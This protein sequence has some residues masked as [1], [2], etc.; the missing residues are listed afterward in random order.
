MPT[1]ISGLGSGLDID[2]LVKQTMQAK[3]VPFDQ[4]RQKMTYLG[5]QRDA[6]R[7]MNTDMSGLLKE[8]QKL[9]FESNVQ[10]KKASMTTSDAEKVIATPSAG[11]V[12][13]NF[14]L[15]VN[16][17]AKSASVTSGMVIGMSTNQL[18]ASGTLTITGSVGS[19]TVDFVV[20][21]NVSQ[22]VSKINSKTSTT[23]VK[24]I[25]DQLSDKLTLTNTQTGAAGN[26]LRIADSG[27]TNTLLGILKI[28]DTDTPDPTRT[29]DLT[30]TAQTNVS[31]GQDA[32]VNFNNTG[33]VTVSSNSFTMNNINFTLLKDPAALGG[34]YT[35]SGSTNT[36]VDAIV[37]TIKGVF[38]KYNDL[39]DKVN[40]K[41]SEPKYRDY[42]PLSDDQKAEMKEADI[43]LWEEKAKSGLLRRDSVLSNG[44]EKMRHF[45]SESVTG[46]AAGQYNSMADIGITT[47][48]SS[49]ASSYQAYLENGKIY[50]DE[51]KLRNALTNSPD[52]VAALFTKDGARDVNGKLTN[53]TDAGIGTRLNEI[54][55]SDIISGLTQKTQI[56][57]T[58]SY[59]NRQID[60]YATRIS[61]GESVLSKYEQQLYSKYAKMETALNKLNSQGSYLQSF[62]Q[63]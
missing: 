53:W 62:S 38:D 7:E 18:N 21:D 45:L 16:Q 29:P 47:A 6:Y 31:K 10:A 54:V 42:A 2:T 30:T 22:I 17:I 1:R 46:I 27:G 20:T 40:G 15:Q 36:D 39:I 52:Q 12:S 60:D 50:I 11:A 34:T 26:A 63:Q 32:I 5:W 61:V 24:A 44:L 23:G 55:N 51:S 57:P 41:L 19:D 33:N 56:V 49:G 8:V 4:M 43:K 58:K 14:T 35:I 13:G 25:Y 37:S 9:T 3:R 48:P 28:S 59:L